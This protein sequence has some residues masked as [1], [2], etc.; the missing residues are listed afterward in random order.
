MKLPLK[1]PSW[2]LL[3]GCVVYTAYGLLTGLS[4]TTVKLDENGNVRLIYSRW[5][6]LM[7]EDAMAG[8]RVDYQE[9]DF[10]YG[11]WYDSTNQKAI[12]NREQVDFH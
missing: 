4:T 8:F 7:E 3:A 9:G 11:L 1:Y 5:W 10:K 2:T 12:R 6:G